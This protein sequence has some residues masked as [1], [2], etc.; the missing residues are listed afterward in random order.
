MFLQLFPVDSLG[1]TNYHCDRYVN[2]WKQWRTDE[3]ADVYVP[4]GGGLMK[5]CWFVGN[6]SQILD[7]NL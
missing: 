5:T 2:S 3:L 1:I 6:L 7:K 4:R